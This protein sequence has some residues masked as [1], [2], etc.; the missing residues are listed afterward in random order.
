M[1]D[2][3]ATLVGQRENRTIWFGEGASGVDE[4]GS[5]PQAACDARGGGVAAVSTV[6]IVAVVAR[7]AVVAASCATRSRFNARRGAIAFVSH[8]MQ[9]GRAP[10]GVRRGHA[11]RAT[12]R[13]RGPTHERPGDERLTVDL[14]DL[15]CRQMT[16]VLLAVAAMVSLGLVAMCT[17]SRDR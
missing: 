6:A 17:G 16:V 9:S 13:C 11:A 2:A 12:A 4:G 1:S 7:V 5:G 10:G 14:Q 3:V 15:R 8:G